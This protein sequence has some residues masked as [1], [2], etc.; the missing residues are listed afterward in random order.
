MGYDVATLK[1]EVDSSGL[2][3]GSQQLDQFG[4]RAATAEKS[5]ARMTK[6][7]G[8]LGAA[9]AAL[10]VGAA[11]N[12]AI[13]KAHDFDKA[14]TEVSTLLEG[15]PAQMDELRKSAKRLSDAYGGDLTANTRAFYQAISAG[16]SSVEAANVVVEQANKLAKGGMTDV[17]TAVDGLTSAMNAYAD[18]NLSAA[19]AS[20]ALF[21]GMKFGKTTIAELSGSL[22]RVAPLAYQAGLS[23]DELVGAI[24]IA[25]K[26][27]IE[28]SEAVSGLKAALANVL[29]PSEQAAALA[30]QLGVEFNAAAL[31]SKGLV[32]FLGDVRTATG[33][34][35]EALTTLFGSIEG[36]N[37]IMSLTGAG[38]ADLSSI[39][40][41]FAQKAGSTDDAVNKVAASLSDRLAVA[42]NKLSNAGVGLGELGLQLQVFA[43]ETAVAATDAFTEAM[44]DVDGGTEALKFLLASFS[45]TVTQVAADVVGTVGNMVATVAATLQGDWKSAWD[46]ALDVVSSFGRAA[47][48]L[49]LGLGPKMS[50]AL[51]RAGEPLRSHAERIGGGVPEGISAGTHIGKLDFTNLQLQLQAQL[52][53]LYAQG[54]GGGKKV[55]AVIAAGVEQGAS[56][57]A[58]STAT[59]KVGF[60]M[61]SGITQG[62]ENQ[63]PKFIDAAGNIVDRAVDRIRDDLEIQSPSRV[64]MR[65]GED[66]MAGLSVGI[67]SS[68]GEVRKAVRDVTRGVTAFAQSEAGALGS[69]FT[70]GADNPG[71]WDSFKT[72]AIGSW[73]DIMATSFAP[74]GAAMNAMEIGLADAIGKAVGAVGSPVGGM[75]L[76]RRGSTVGA[77][78]GGWQFWK[79]PWIKMQMEDFKDQFLQSWMGFIS[80]TFEVVDRGFSGAFAGNSFVQEWAD[81]LKTVKKGNTVKTTTRKDNVRVAAMGTDVQLPGSGDSFDWGGWD[82]GWNTP[83]DEDG[84]GGETPVNPGG[85]NTGG[86][87][88]VSQVMIR[89]KRK[90]AE[91]AKAFDQVTGNIIASI[92][93]FGDAIGGEIDGL[94]AIRHKFNFSI[95]PDGDLSTAAEMFEANMETYSNK[96][97][98]AVLSG[99]KGIQRAG[100]TWVETLERLAHDYWGIYGTMKLLG[101]QRFDNTVLGARQ[102]SELAQL[103]GGSDAFNEAASTYFGVAYSPE[104]QKSRIE[105]YIKDALGSIGIAGMPTTREE[106]KALVDAQNLGNDEGRAAYQLLISL[107]GMFDQVLP[108]WESGSAELAAAMQTVTGSLSGLIN[109]AKTAQYRFEA[110]A[111]SLTSNADAVRA[112]GQSETQTFDILRSRFNALYAQSLGGDADAMGKI[113]DVATSL[114]RASGSRATS[115]AEFQWITAGIASKLDALS[116]VA[117][118]QAAMSAY[119]S[120]SLQALLDAVDNGT[121]N[122]E[123]VAQ[124]VAAVGSLEDAIMDGLRE[125]YI[126]QSG[127]VPMFAAGGVH[128]GGLR[129]VGENGPE[130]EATGPARIWSSAQTRSMLGADGL[131]SDMRKMHEQTRALSMRMEK[132]ERRMFQILD[133]WDREGQPDTR[134]AS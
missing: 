9:A 29:R 39:M 118:G 4:Q 101:E 88:T 91:L 21:V 76:T 106:Y 113:G 47:T 40:G 12:K 31:A 104:Q 61:F 96:L 43:A 129:V 131:R 80:T 24:S 11:F 112:M 37:L 28:T 127:E 82:F 23:F 13:Q 98:K 56:Q 22:G 27:G 48:A 128:R 103:F 15:T 26:G 73:R 83:D 90:N 10:G 16:A 107:A 99:Q 123:L 30:G 105:K 49:T 54:W 38:F 53:N 68:G 36:A 20:D 17:F 46:N 125:I 78:S 75:N 66:M 25:T 6:A 14:L 8:A 134:A 108:A 7:I 116:G 41:A 64:M 34:S 81:Y 52:D 19:D 70:G 126:S 124:T 102:A 92:S 5:A 87:T 132:H 44:S 59:V 33:G 55:G 110:L 115:A 60:D 86:G 32:G 3:K 97:A 2:R 100:E 67:E 93:Y 89:K 69:A 121:L 94:A 51:T 72:L 130:L 45:A 120:E 57:T 84:A 95:G 85:G 79:A 65:I 62:M 74:G 58:T 114:A 35:T 71:F 77:Q 63:G 117:A 122:N 119:E 50:E 111:E 109:T 133:K 42:L 18:A 1:L